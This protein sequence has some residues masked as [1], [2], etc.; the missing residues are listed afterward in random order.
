MADEERAA[1]TP[2]PDDDEAAAILAALAT[3]LAAQRRPTAAPPRAVSRW[4][5]AGRLA[6]QGIA[7]RRIPGTAVG[8]KD[9]GRKS[10]Q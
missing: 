1:I 3:Y 2:T 4:A 10:V 9:V 5:L 8:W 7:A 6:S